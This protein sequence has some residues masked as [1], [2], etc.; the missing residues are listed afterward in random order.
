[1]GCGFD[2][3]NRGFLPE[4]PWVRFIHCFKNIAFFRKMT[5]LQKTPKFD[6]N[7]TDFGLDHDFATEAALGVILSIFK[8]LVDF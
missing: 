2:P 1:L 3:K 4:A 7:L 6:Q 5:I 8:I